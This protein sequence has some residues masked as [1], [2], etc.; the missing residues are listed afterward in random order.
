MSC[1]RLD[2][3]DAAVPAR[4]LV[5]FL[6]RTQGERYARVE[7]DGGIAVHPRAVQRTILEL[8]LKT[9]APAGTLVVMLRPWRRRFLLYPRMVDLGAMLRSATVPCDVELAGPLPRI[10]ATA[11][12][13]ALP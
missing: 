2:G 11:R 8:A 13:R 3:V 12:R 9:L 5:A 4:D 6:A 1:L 10:V 7:I